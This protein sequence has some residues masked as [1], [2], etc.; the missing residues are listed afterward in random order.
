MTSVISYD[1]DRD[2]HGDWEGAVGGRRWE[3]WDDQG[4]CFVSLRIV[5]WVGEV[6][7]GWSVMVGCSTSVQEIERRQLSRGG[8]SQR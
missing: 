7:V 3:G 8:V 6:M 2:S 1:R 4:W 5:T